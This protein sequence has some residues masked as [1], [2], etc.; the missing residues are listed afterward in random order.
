M[1]RSSRLFRITRFKC[2]TIARHEATSFDRAMLYVCLIRHLLKRSSARLAFE[3]E[4]R[5]NDS[6]LQQIIDQF[7]RR[8][9]HHGRFSKHPRLPELSTC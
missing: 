6:R 4:L 1:I 5:D 3:K 8:G 2:S 7:F 9:A